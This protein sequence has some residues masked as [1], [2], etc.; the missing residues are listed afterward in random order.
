MNPVEIARLDDQ[1][2][3]V[4]RSCHAAY[5]DRSVIDGVSPHSGQST[6]RGSFILRTSADSAS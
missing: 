1:R 6:S 5:A 3:L 2:Q 4:R